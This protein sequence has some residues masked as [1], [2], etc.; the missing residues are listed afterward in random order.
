[1]SAQ[2][3][4]A[5]V[6]AGKAS[7]K[8]PRGVFFWKGAFWIRYA[9]SQGRYRRERAG[10]KGMAIDLYR[11]RK[12]EALAGVKLPERLRRA[13]VSFDEIAK[14]ALSYSE[15]HKRSHQDDAYRMGTIL[16][17]FGGRGAESITPTEIERALTD[18]ADEWDWKPATINRHRSLLSLTYRLAIRNRRVKENPVRQVTRRKENNLRV[19]FLEAE[20]EIT[21]RAK[22]RELCPEREPEFDLALNTGMRRN[23]QWRLRLADVNLRSGILTIRDAKNGQGR[24]V[25]INSAADRALVALS[26]QS[27]G[28]HVVPGPTERAVRT[29]DRW[30]EECVEEAG[31]ADFRYHDIRHTFG[32]RLAMAGVPLRTLAELL[33]HRTL[34]MVMRYAHLSPGHL[35]DAVERISG[36]PTDTTTDTGRF[37]VEQQQEARPN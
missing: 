12:L 29:W 4:A 37:A 20:E 3:E 33:G 34:A 7:R 35:R 27:N 22:I 2:V 8:N 10:T 31:V 26:K 9:D 14:D 16:E 28:E 11:K 18:A 1:M 15:T 13:I 5:A 25:P 32:S 19:R 6:Q 30:F 24:H 17:W 36:T 21:L 23:E